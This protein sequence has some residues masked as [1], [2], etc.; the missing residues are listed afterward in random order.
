MD[1]STESL[2]EDRHTHGETGK[3]G[4]CMDASRESQYKDR[5]T[6]EK[7]VKR[8]TPCGPVQHNDRNWTETSTQNEASIKWK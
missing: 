2:C 8:T 3:K 5:H 7:Q 4:N 1:T 6:T